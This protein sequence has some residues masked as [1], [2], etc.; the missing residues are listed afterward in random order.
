MAITKRLVKGSAL[1]QA[2]LDENFTT[3]VNED[4]RTDNPHNVTKAQVGLGS[5]DNTS[6][7]NKPVSTAQA[8]AI[9]AAQTAAQT[10]AD[11]LVVGLWD[12]RGNFDASVNAYP[13]TGGSGSAG[14]IK[15][16]DIWTVSVAGTL[17]NSKAVGV[18][19][20][21]R[22]LIDTPGN[23]QSNWAIAENN[24]GYVPE[25]VA[26]KG[27]ANGY[28][29]LGADSRTPKANSYALTTPAPVNTPVAA[30]M[31]PQQVAE[32]LQGQANNILSIANTA[33][34]NSVKRYGRFS[35]KSIVG[36]GS[37]FGSN[38]LEFSDGIETTATSRMPYNIIGKSVQI[39]VYFTNF[40]PI[41]QKNT[42]QTFNDITIEASLEY[43]AG[44]F[45]RITFS[46][47]E[48]TFLLKKGFGVESDFIKTYIP[49]G[50]TCWIR[51]NVLVTVGQ[52]WQKNSCTQ[53]S[54]GLGVAGVVA[55]VN[56]VMSGTITNSTTFCYAPTAVMGISATNKASV[57]LFGDSRTTGQGDTVGLN[58]YYYGQK[59][60][61]YGRSFQKDYPLMSLNVFAQSATYWDKSQSIVANYYDD[62]LSC[63]QF[64]IENLGINDIISSTMAQIQTYIISLW[65]YCK[66][67]GIKMVTLTYE[68]YTTSTDGWTTL[69][70]QTVLS[71]ESKRLGLNAWKRDGAPIDVTTLLAVAV[72]VTG[73][74]IVRVGNSRHPL[75]SIIDTAITV[76]DMATGKWRV[77]LG[78]LTADG[79]HA[80]PTGYAINV[81]PITNAL[82][83]FSV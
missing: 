58:N 78:A 24:I 59:G 9:S 38:N 8:T 21:V 30:G 33:A 36:M 51:T 5:V 11:N 32:A 35:N 45:T 55:G 57:L 50:V 10:Y 72:G 28:A 77:D 71:G 25:N 26:N 4:S 68:P 37:R 31:D 34:N 18:G 13:S 19:D 6:D 60:G 66:I 65:Y 15:K 64:G 56:S 7:T 74:N 23:I 17:P 62:L 47:G 63:A 12:D 42:L 16:G 3:L 43:P 14:A 76:E 53:S 82:S 69:P 52:V 2:E 67:R 29:P 39:S 20:T 81:V 54:G 22:A 27:T 41:A 44:T 1:T 75:F 70:N 40:E 61:L 79:L 49:E 83:I 80:N 48:T 73:S 46:N